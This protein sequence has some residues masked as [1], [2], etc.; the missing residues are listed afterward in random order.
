[1]APRARFDAE[2][3][4]IEAVGGHHPPHREFAR[5]VNREI[6][7]ETGDE[8]EGAEPPA[9]RAAPFPARDRSGPASPSPRPSARRAGR[10]ARSGS[11]TIRSAIDFQ[12]IPLP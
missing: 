8:I 7:L 5:I 3:D 11:S 4:R 2:P 6:E 10:P 9:A 1:M 12:L